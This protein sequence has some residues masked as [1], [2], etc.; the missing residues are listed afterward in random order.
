MADIISEPQKKQY[1]NELKQPIYIGRLCLR[2]RIVFSPVTTRFASLSGAVTRQLINYHIERA[3]GGVGLQIVEG[4]TV[5]DVFAPGLLK[6]HSDE[7]LPG[8]NELAES[9]KMWGAAAAIQLNH[10]GKL[11]GRDLNNMSSLEIE[12]CVE[13]FGEAVLRMKKAGFD[14]VEIHGA[15]A[16]LIAQFL[17]PLTNRRSDKWGG[18]LENRARFAL[19]IVRS[20]RKKVGPDFPLSF[21][22]SGDEFL[23]GGLS[24][25]ETPLISKWLVAEGINLINVSGGGPQTREW[26]GLPAAFPGGALVY[27]AEQIKKHLDVPVVAVG[28][29][30]DPVLANSIVRDG[31]ADLVA[32]GRALVADPQFPV[33][34]FSGRISEIRRC[35]ACMECRR[36]V[37]D[38]SYKLKCS[39]NPEVGLEDSCVLLPTKKTRKMMVIG[40]GPGGMEAAQTLRL[41]GHEVSLWEQKQ[42]LGGQLHEAKVPPG[43]EEWGNFIAYQEHQMRL[44]DIHVHMGRRVDKQTIFQEKPDVVLVATGSQEIMPDLGER[45]GPSIHAGREILTTELSAGKD[46]LVIGGGSVGCELADYLAEKGLK[47]ALIEMLDRIG[48]DL[49]S[50]VRKILLKRFEEKGVKIYTSSKVTGLVEGGAC[51]L[52]DNGKTIEVSA[53]FIVVCIGARPENNLAQELGQAPDGPEVHVIGDASK[54]GRVLDAVHRAYW[55]G[56]T[57]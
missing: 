56:R 24:V 14:L 37:V 1:F 4:A 49:E 8:L 2:N 32:L 22:I 9:I 25:E 43:K 51:V 41:R 48:V 45:H 57:L 44:L 15:H 42:T 39:I 16:Y 6:A 18:S 12:D 26:T 40:G 46:A 35:V 28:R 50:N 34:A 53:D 29:I 17:S 27:L 5:E 20:A 31:R 3:K 52:Q 7:L 10:A 19:A 55:L 13:L 21:R 23:S 30:N 11:V 47:V 33:K 54:A 38:L 36:R